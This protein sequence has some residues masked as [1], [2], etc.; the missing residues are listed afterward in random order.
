MF[1]RFVFYDGPSMIDGKP[2]VGIATNVLRASKNA[3]TGAMVQTYVMR[4]D[5]EPHLAV[6]TGDDISVCD[7]CPHRSI[8][9]G[10][11]GSCYVIPFRAPLSV[12]RAWQRGNFDTPTPGEAADRLAGLKVRMGSYGNPSAIPF[13]VWERLLSKTSGHSGYDHRWTEIDLQWSRLVMASAD[14]AQEAEHA[15]RLGYRTFRVRRESDP[16]LPS[17][18]VCPAATEA[19]K[20][21]SCSECRQ[22]DGT[23]TGVGRPSRVIIAHGPTAGRF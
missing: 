1:N 5:I 8:A 23:S 10:G 4:S 17:E 12:H 2:I 6:K 14:S 19:G 3:K 9:S 20:V 21:L 18:R 15:H 11:K 16:I 13:H 22:C 7:G